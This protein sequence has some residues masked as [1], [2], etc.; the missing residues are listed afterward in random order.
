MNTKHTP[1]PL[2]NELMPPDSKVLDKIK[3]RLKGIKSDT[4]EDIIRA[5]WYQTGFEEAIKWLRTN[6]I[7]MPYAA[8][9]E[10]LEALQKIA[11]QS[12][13]IGRSGCTYGDTEFDSLSACY[14]ANQQLNYDKQIAL[15]A[16]QKATK[17]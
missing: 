2:F 9:P 11:N 15:N 1:A 14:G 12:E 17:P 10:L 6:K 4:E 5:V 13:E 7:P 3:G 16:I 8:A